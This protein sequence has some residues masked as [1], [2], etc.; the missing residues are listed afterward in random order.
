[1]CT[2]TAH[3][4]AVYSVAFSPNCTHVC[5][6]GDEHVKIWDAATGAEVRSFVGVR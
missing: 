3:T 1:M 5:A 2:L 6:S 4:G